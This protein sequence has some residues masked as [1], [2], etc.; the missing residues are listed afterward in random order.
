MAKFS[1]VPFYHDTKG[2]LFLKDV[3]AH[4]VSVNKPIPGSPVACTAPQPV[5][6][7]REQGSGR[8]IDVSGAVAALI[9]VFC[10]PVVTGVWAQ[11]AGVSAPGLT[12]C[13]Q[14]SAAWAPLPALMVVG[15]IPNPVL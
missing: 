7:K 6:Q 10:R 2:L 9:S 5:R 14:M 8:V 4:P 3:S 12:G 15:R 1:P 13:S 11:R